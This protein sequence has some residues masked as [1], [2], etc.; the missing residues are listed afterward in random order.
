LPALLNTVGI[1]LPHRRQARSEDGAFL[2]WNVSN[3]TPL[4]QSQA[5]IAVVLAKIPLRVV[6]DFVS[7]F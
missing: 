4:A 7:L 6:Y 2:R 1:P 5:N 3:I